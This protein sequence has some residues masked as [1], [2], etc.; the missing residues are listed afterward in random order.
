MITKLLNDIYDSGC[1][2]NDLLKSI[3]IALPKKSR[4][5]ECEDHRTISLMSH[6]TKILLRIIMRRMR[7][8]IRPEISDEQCGFVEG[9]G[10]SN[11]IYILRTLIE[12]S[13]E[14]KT[15]LY[16]CFIDYTKAFDNVNHQEL[17]KMLESLNIDSKDLRVIQN[18]YWQQTAAIRID[19][20]IGTFQ[21]IK[22]SVGQGCVL[23][24]DLFSLYCESSF[25]SLKD[26]P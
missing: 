26:T 6:M 21:K 2:P 17:S 9:K 1:I 12:R 8:R 3:F 5:V 15:D 18:I 10:T 22:K 16:L 7:S 25:R 24:P 23:S 19:K 11:A 20:K 13:I 14:V 4:A